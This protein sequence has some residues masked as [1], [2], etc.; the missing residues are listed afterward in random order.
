MHIC[1]VR[2]LDLVHVYIGTNSNHCYE[3]V[4]TI[5]C[6]LVFVSHSQRCYLHISQESVR[7]L[8]LFEM[9]FQSLS[10]KLRGMFKVMQHLCL[11]SAFLK[12]RVNSLT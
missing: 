7:Y 9:Y 10:F 12:V 1:T 11:S 3:I 8:S 2:R 6:Q 5:K 4:S